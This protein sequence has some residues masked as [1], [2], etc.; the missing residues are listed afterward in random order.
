GNREGGRVMSTSHFARSGLIRQGDLLLVPVDAIDQAGQVVR[1]RTRS[2]HVLAEG[3][4][5]GHAHVLHGTGLR[6]LEWERH[7]RWG[8][9]ESRRYVQVAGPSGLVHREPL[10]LDVAPGVYEVRRQREY[11]PGRGIWGSNDS[12]WVM[13]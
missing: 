9:F 6:L 3:E 1:K 8:R 10:P 13:D 2:E 5:T 7:G 4:A 12:A 11:R